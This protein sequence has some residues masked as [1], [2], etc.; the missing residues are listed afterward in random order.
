MTRRPYLLA[1]LLL[2]FAAHAGFEVSSFRGSGTR[3][4][5][6]HAAGAALDGDLATAWMVHP[7]QENAG[8]WLTIDVPS[9]TVAKIGIVS[10]WDKDERTFSNHARIKKARIIL[11][12]LNAGE[13][14]VVFDKEVELKDA[15]GWQYIDVP[16]VK[17]G[18]DLRG[19]QF[20]L[21]ATEFYPG[22]DFPT[23]AVSEVRVILKEFPAE[24]SQLDEPLSGT[25]DTSKAEHLTDKNPKTVW[26]ATKSEG[27]TFTLKAPGYGLAS[28]EL[29]QGPKPHARPK[30]V[31]IK[32][33]DAVVT[34]TLADKPGQ[35]QT[36]L[37]PVVIGYTGSSWG[38][39]EVTVVDS[40]P[41]DAGKGL[42]IAEARLTAATIDD[43]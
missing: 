12:N 1:A 27:V 33:N 39:V 4:D 8:Q 18:S 43:L 21:V 23:L 31:T 17:V 32:A 34:H 35:M 9:S 37:L 26:H 7:E 42:A 10:G 3:I 40:Y 25:A 13:A 16:E 11:S 19:G 30:T 28:I 22:R 5:T 36:M 24:T 29:V 6:T 15:R 14:E 20:K 2:P 38:T 41:G